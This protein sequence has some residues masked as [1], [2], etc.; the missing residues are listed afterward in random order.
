MDDLIPTDWSAQLSSVIGSDHFKRLRAFVA[1]ERADH[2][3][4][5]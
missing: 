5:I 4:Q 3:G 1:Q 2:P